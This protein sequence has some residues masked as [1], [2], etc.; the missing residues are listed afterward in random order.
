MLRVRYR[1]YRGGQ[2]KIRCSAR[3]EVVTSSEANL[4][5]AII[6]S[7]YRSSQRR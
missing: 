6:T 7:T 4:L 5:G 1:L 2:I 3:L